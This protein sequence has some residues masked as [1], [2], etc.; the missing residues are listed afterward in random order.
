MDEQDYKYLISAYQQKSFDLLSQLT[1]CE[2]K[3]KKLM[4]I[5]D[6]LNSVIVEQ[7]EELK[8]LSNKQRKS[9]KIEETY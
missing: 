1:T 6:N 3:N 8:K 7:Q 2:A 4:D 5:V 9:V